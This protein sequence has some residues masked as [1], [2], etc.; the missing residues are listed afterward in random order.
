MPHKKEIH[1][2]SILCQDSL[3]YLERQ[4]DGSIKNIVTGF[5]DMDEL[6]M[7]SE[8]YINYFNKALDLIFKKTNEN[9]YIIFIQTDRK[10]NGIIDKSY[11]I[12]K[13]AEEHSYRTIFHKIVLLRNPG[14]IDIYRPS[15]SHMLCYSVKGKPGKPTPDVLKVSKKKYKNSTPDDACDFAVRFVKGTVVDLFCG[16][17]SILESCK[18]YNIDA[19][20]IDIDINQCTIARKN[21][22]Q[23]EL[24]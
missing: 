3:E 2:I 23:D 7:S 12:S 17:G 15:Y 10:K 4:Q 6:S 9:G 24:V 11:I 1:N 5:P 13:K 16:R 14:A 22:K 21:L 20:G 8:D 19:I 18:K